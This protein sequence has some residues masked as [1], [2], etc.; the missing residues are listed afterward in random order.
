M[1]DC[2]PIVQDRT[3]TVYTM[4]ELDIGGRRFLALITND[5][6][7]AAQPNIGLLNAKTPTSSSLLF[8][9]CKDKHE[10]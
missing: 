2:R 9:I 5:L 8:V 7:Y 10:S 6:I 3:L 1:K 4:H